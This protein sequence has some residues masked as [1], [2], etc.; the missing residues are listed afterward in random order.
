MFALKVYAVASEDMDSLAFGAPRFL[1]HLMDPTS[2]RIPVVEYEVS[3][4]LMLA[5]PRKAIFWCCSFPF[6]RSLL[7]LYPYLSCI[8]RQVM[9]ELNLSMDQ[10][11][12]LC[13]LSG[14]DYCESIRGNIAL[15][16]VVVV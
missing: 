2:K 16:V 1:C 7:F 4:V 9:E 12:D 5:G 6:F 13:I 15:P 14:C 3:R 10:F 8:G 11:I